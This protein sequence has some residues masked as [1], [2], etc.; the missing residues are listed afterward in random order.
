ME[1]DPD[2]Q[3]KALAFLVEKGLKCPMCGTADWEWQENKFAYEAVPHRC[4]GCYVRDSATDDTQR[5]PGVTVE[6]HPTG[7]RESALRQEKAAQAHAKRGP[8]REARK[9]R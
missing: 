2:D 3:A 6:L 4:Q 1:W 9:R 7:T 8:A 5:Q